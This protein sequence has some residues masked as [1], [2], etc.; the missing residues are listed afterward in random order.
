MMTDAKISKLM[1]YWL[2]H[3]PEDARLK[4]SDA[5]WTDV[6]ALLNALKDKGVECDLERLTG[7]VADNDK[8]RFQLSG[9]GRSIRAR[10]GH[11]IDVDLDLVSI[12]P[13]EVLYHGT[14]ERFLAAIWRDGLKPMQRHHVHL[15][16]DVE[17]ARAVGKRHGKPAILHVLAEAMDQNGYR[18]YRTNNGV[19][20]VD[21]VPPEFLRI[22]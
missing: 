16:G 13:P 3:K 11:S 10:Q 15:S 4:L 1:S 8:K 2:R 7:I 5:G 18:F 20:L 6:T 14:A 12:T 9:D 22:I 21:T 17:T 19:W